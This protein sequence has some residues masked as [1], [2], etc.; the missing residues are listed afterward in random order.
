M[1]DNTCIT[2][3]MLGFGNL[4][5]SVITILIYK[6]LFVSKILLVS[7]ENAFLCKMSKITLFRSLLFYAPHYYL[8]YNTYSNFCMSINT[9][10]KQCVCV[11]FLN[12][13]SY[14]Q[15][16]TFWSSIIN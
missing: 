8:N 13:L 10:T 14:V 12:T 6:E 15:Y 7:N 3:L 11:L 4:V 16:I 5:L 9:T 1:K 2:A